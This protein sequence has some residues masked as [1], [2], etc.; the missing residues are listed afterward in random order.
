MGDKVCLHQKASIAEE[1]MPIA[2]DLFRQGMRRLGGAVTIVSTAHDDVRAGL[3]ATAVTSLSAEP[4]R[5][6]ACINRQGGTYDIISRSRCLAVNVLGTDFK[7]LA[8][9][10]A[11]LDGEPE[12]ERFSEG[13]WFEAA[14]G[15]PLL[16]GALVGFDCSVESILDAGSHAIVIGNIEAVNMPE[17]SAENLDD[18]L[19]YINGDWATLQVLPD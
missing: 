14:T 17:A 3:T 1:D 10:F 13:I 9:R 4:P 7:Q 19:C 5:L 16:K 15:A 11:G 8:M 12:T 2:P 6:L 18:P